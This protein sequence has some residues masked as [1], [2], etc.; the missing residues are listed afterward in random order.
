MTVKCKNT[1]LAQHKSR[2]ETDRT[3]VQPTGVLNFAHEDTRSPYSSHMQSPWIILNYTHVTQID[4]TTYNSSWIYPPRANW[5]YYAWS[6]WSPVIRNVTVAQCLRPWNYCWDL[7]WRDLWS[8]LAEIW[9]FWISAMKSLKLETS[10]IDQSRCLTF[11]FF[12]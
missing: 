6:M 1:L 5:T 4:S 8:H 10:W 11:T 7:S 9:T 2:T 12:L 3:L